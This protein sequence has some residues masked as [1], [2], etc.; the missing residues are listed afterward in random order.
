MISIGVAISSYG[1]LLFSLMGFVLQFISTL[2]ETSR[3][4][5]ADKFLRD[6]KLD[7]LSLLYYLSPIC[8]LLISIAFVIFELDTMPFEIFCDINFIGMLI[9]SGLVSFAL[10]LAV[11]LLMSNS[12]ALTLSLGGIIKDILLV[13]LSVFIFHSPVTSIQIFG[14]S[15]SLLG[16]VLYK[17]CKSNPQGFTS[18]VLKLYDTLQYYALHIK[19]KFM[20]GI[21]NEKKVS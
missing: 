1:E 4:V 17:S 5:L 7:S 21:S 3:L 11:V 6:L 15:I 10:N 14:Y 2:C 18:A 9:L 16:I 12:S 13:L 19:S 8:F 20:V